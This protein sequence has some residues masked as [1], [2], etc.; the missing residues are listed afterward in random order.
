[1]LAESLGHLE[2]LVLIRTRLGEVHH[3][4]GDY[5][6]A[7]T[8]FRQNI[9]A[10][11]GEH[12]LE[13]FGLLQPPA[14]HSRTWLVSSLSELGMFQEARSVAAEAL[15]IAQQID[16]P[17]ALN[18]AWAGA[19]QAALHQGNVDEAVH[20]LECAANAW[21]GDT[22][23]WQPVFIGALGLAHALSGDSARGI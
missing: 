14:V 12:A 13:R 9:A 11:T 1:A 2:P 15:A 6:E 20:A 19:G 16:E 8:L 23:P 18:F 4:R 5:T 21:R 3:G 22:T 10:L 7:A 17:V